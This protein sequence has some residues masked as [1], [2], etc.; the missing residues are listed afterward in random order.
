MTVKQRFTVTRIKTHSFEIM[1]RD[2]AYKLERKKDHITLE[3]LSGSE[4]IEHLDVYPKADGLSVTLRDRTGAT[5]THSV[6]LAGNSISSTTEVEGK[7]F[8]VDSTQAHYGEKFAA[9]LHGLRGG[10]S[11]THMLRFAKELNIDSEFQKALKIP[12]T[13][14]S[15][16]TVF[17]LSPSCNAICD[18]AGNPV[19]LKLVGPAGAV[20]LSAACLGCHLQEAGI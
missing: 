17:E 1:I 16:L 19:T 13:D 7:S 9:A 4:M 12:K 10:P 14:P 15:E 2:S 11:G 3:A 8:Q 18:A 20:A 5:M 6:K